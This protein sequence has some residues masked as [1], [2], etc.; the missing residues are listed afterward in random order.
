[1]SADNSDDLG[2]GNLKPHGYLT[3]A[4][5]IGGRDQ[6]RW[7][8][9]GGNSCAPP[10]RRVLLGASGGSDLFEELQASPQF[11]L[12]NLSRSNGVLQLPDAT[13]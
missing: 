12:A 8:R 7:H 6:A 13:S 10:T 2:A 11:S 1:M 5:L 4:L 9:R 3:R